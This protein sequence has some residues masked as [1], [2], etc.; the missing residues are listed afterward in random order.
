MK[1]GKDRVGSMLLSLQNTMPKSLQKKSCLTSSSVLHTVLLT[2]LYSIIFPK[3]STLPAL[4]DS[5]K[6]EL[7]SATHIGFLFWAGLRY[8]ERN[9]RHV[10][11]VPS[12]TADSFHRS[13]IWASLFNLVSLGS[14]YE[15]FCFKLPL[16]NI[17]LCRTEA[18]K[19]IFVSSHTNKDWK[20]Y[21]SF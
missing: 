4:S 15:M 6:A 5:Q 1:W 18:R 14:F 8:S 20:S 9:W 11:E 16:I 17:D 7:C 19:A 10:L 3:E 2:V 21:S 12:M 13:N